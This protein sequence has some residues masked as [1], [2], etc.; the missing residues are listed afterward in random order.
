MIESI[1]FIEFY[2][3]LMCGA[4]G[5]WKLF[6]ILCT[7]ELDKPPYHTQLQ[8]IYLST[9]CKERLKAHK[10]EMVAKAKRDAKEEIALRK[11]ATK[12]LVKETTNGTHS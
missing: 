6:P 8:N 1:E 3:G 9:L 10:K 7:L 2:V 5:A 11:E 12:K 4:F